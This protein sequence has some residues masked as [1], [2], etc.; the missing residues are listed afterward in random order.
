MMCPKVTCLTNGFVTVS[1][2]NSI[3]HLVFCVTYLLIQ[4]VEVFEF[5]FI[6]NTGKHKKKS[7]LQKKLV[8]SKTFRG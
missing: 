3:D 6:K 7:L 2:F 5:S 4:N 8:Q 1:D